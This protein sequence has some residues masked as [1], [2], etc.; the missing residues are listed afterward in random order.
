L[1]GNECYLTTTFDGIPN[2]TFPIQDLGCD[3]WFNFEN[4]SKFFGGR[5]IPFPLL[6]ILFYKK[7]NLLHVVKHNVGFI[8]WSK[9]C[10]NICKTN[11]MALMT[12]RWQE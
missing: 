10:K 1:F 9:S 8:F 4:F 5:V 2:I 3:C 11:T 6:V 7:D 12:Y